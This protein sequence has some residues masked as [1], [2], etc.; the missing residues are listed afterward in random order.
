MHIEQLD[1]ISRIDPAEW[2][3]L[4]GNDA[5]YSH[6]WLSTVE[7]STYEQTTFLYVLAR[8]EGV[9]VG[10]AAC[11]VRTGNESASLSKAF[12]GRASGLARATG[13]GA[14]PAIVVGSRYGFSPPFIFDPS[15]S[16][17]RCEEVAE[18]LIGRI[19]E[20]A[21]SM[22]ASVMLRNTKPG[23]FVSALSRAHFV[24]TPD[25]PTTYIDIRWRDFAEFRRDLKKIHPATE[26]AIRNQ[27]SRAKRDGVVVERLSDPKML[28]DELFDVLNSHHRR[29]N[30]VSLPFS[31]SFLSEAFRWLG[32]SADLTIA[33]DASGI[34]G[35]QF[36]LRKN[37]V[38]HALLVGTATERARTTHAYYL[39]LNHVM[40]RAIESGDRRLYFGRQLY[41]VKARRGCSI[42][43]SMIWIR[44]RSRLQRA[45]LRRVVP[46]RSRKIERMIRALEPGSR[47]NAAALQGS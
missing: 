22:K 7:A 35:V 24:G 16:P 1:S 25:V 38:S 23:T 36:T 44:G 28:S 34:L 4:S 43:Q 8:N 47:S 17:A 9:L 6:D 40:N 45:G 11:Q 13:F 32:D 3:C 39:L 33:R 37:G 27:T 42:E 20:R 46:I 2:D 31:E 29:L 10:A 30:G 14:T 18:T 15:L 19:V 21:E 5:L 26:K 41:D 12:Y